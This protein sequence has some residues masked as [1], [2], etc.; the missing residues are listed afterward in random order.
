VLHIEIQGAMKPYENTV[1]LSFKERI[2]K[3]PE[4][5]TETRI[6]FV[7]QR[8]EVVAGRTHAGGGRCPGPT[9]TTTTRTVRLCRYWV[10]PTGDLGY[11]GA[12]NG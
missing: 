9:T 8:T 7:S 6:A 1:E 12:R 11:R 3:P 2:G 10:S 5:P 4:N